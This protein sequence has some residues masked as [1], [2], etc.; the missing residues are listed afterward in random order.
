MKSKYVTLCFFG[1]LTATVAS[2]DQARIDSARSAWLHKAQAGD[3]E[4]QYHMGEAYCCDTVEHTRQA[5][6]WYCRAAVQGYADA[7]YEMGRIFAN[8]LPA[9][10]DAI[11]TAGLFSAKRSAYMWFTAAASAGHD[12]SFAARTRLG[13]TMPASAVAEAKRWATRWKQASCSDAGF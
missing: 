4:S 13:A 1:M 7:Q 9:G 11:A 8:D 2:A 5:L 10:S 12:S 3:V 6:H